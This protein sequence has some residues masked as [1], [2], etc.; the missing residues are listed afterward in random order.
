MDKVLLF[1]SSI[2]WQDIVDV[3]LNS[4]ILFR[5]YV[6]FRGTTTLRVLIVIAFLWFFQRIAAYLGLIITSWAVQGVTAVAALIIIVI[7][8][9]EIRSVLQA[10]NLKAILWGVSL[11]TIKT[12][13]EI[14][15][16][17]VYEMA[18]KKIGALIVF[19]AKEDLKELIQNGVPWRGR[20]SKEMI[21]SIFWHGNP[22]HDG[23]AVIQGDQITDVGV[24]LPLSNRKNIPLY[25]GT[26][27]RAAAGLAEITD[28]LVIVVSEE[29]GNVL[30]AKGS[31]MRVIERKDELVTIL[32]E[33]V[34]ITTKALDYVRKEKIKTGLAAVASVLFIIGV[35]FSFSRGLETMITL[36]IPI[37]YMNRDARV[38][39]IDTSVNAVNLNLSGSGTI[40]KTI[41]PDKVNVKLDLSK[42]VIGR[43]T[44]TITEE[45]ITLPPG[46][47]LKGVKPSVVEVTLDVPIVKELPVQVAWTGKLPENLILSEARLDP[48]KLL[49]EGGSHML[50]NISTIYTEKVLLDNISESGKISVK[51]VLNPASLKIALGS[52]DRISIEYVVKKRLQ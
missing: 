31:D 40:I 3:T 22:V 32:Q 44:Y 42:A 35:W 30:V 26:R 43:N 2:R 33:Q 38:E 10:K 11:K 6:L 8:R 23:A 5:L 28:A 51:L 49:V 7:F 41:R 16:E 36:E 39:I 13:V 45:N 21:M 20:I 29:R 14:V 37:E 48:E 19:P 9:N 17:S 27:H 46:A 4:Y 15:V 24:I 50:K 52:K 12:P 25:Y 34:G 1:L 47:F 18:R